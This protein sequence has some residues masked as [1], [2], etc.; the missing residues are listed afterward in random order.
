MSLPPWSE[1]LI[2]LYASAAATQFLLYGNVNDRFLI[3]GKTLGSLYEF[4]TRVMMPRFDVVLSY[5]LGNGVRIDKGGEIV[6]KWPAYRESPEL[7]RAPRPGLVSDRL[8]HEGRASRR[9]RAPRRAELRPQRACAADAR[10]GGRRSAR[11]A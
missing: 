6:Q 8:L 1:K 2:A 3:E 5:D 9:A 4:L 11:A 7:P 10:L